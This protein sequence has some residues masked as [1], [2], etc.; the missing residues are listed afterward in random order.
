MK[1]A[2]RPS[3]QFPS[4]PLGRAL[5]MLAVSAPLGCAAFPVAAQA[6]EYRSV[7]TSTLL[8]E[9]PAPDAEALF[10]L[11]PGTPVE[12]VVRENGWLRVRDPAGGFGWVEVGALVTRRTV[13]VTA[14][15]AVVRR[16]AQETA[17]PAFEATRNV[18]LELLEPASQ[19]WARVRHVEGFEGYVHVSEVWGL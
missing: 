5:L 15:R 4:A 14:E 1:R 3:P 13:I 7:A 19:G 12:I 18:V 9:Q 10:R 6:I 11:R 16:A 2:R 17:E 8:R